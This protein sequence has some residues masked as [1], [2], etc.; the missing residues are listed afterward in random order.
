MWGIA[1][2]LL[3]ALAAGGGYFAWSQ[4]ML[5]PFIPVQSEEPELPAMSPPSETSDIEVELER[6]E[7]GADAELEGYESQL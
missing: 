1:L 5:D 4:G 6:V 7:M 2:V 3:L